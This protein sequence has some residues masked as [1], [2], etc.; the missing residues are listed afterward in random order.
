MIDSPAHVVSLDTIASRADALGLDLRGAFNPVPD[1]EIP[2]LP[3][4]RPVRTLVLLG[5]VGGARW[6]VFAGSPEKADG[7]PDPLDRWSRRVIGGL[8]D[9]LGAT[10][11]FLLGERQINFQRCARRAE[12]V[13]PSPV[14]VL[15]HPEHGLW[16]S[17][18]GALAF[19]DAIDCPPPE[20]TASPCE[21]CIE[22]PCLS[23]CPVGAYTPGRYDLAACAEHLRGPGG[24]I[25]ATLNCRARGACPVGALYRYSDAQTLFHMSN[26]R[27]S[28][29]RHVGAGLLE[30][31]TKWKPDGKVG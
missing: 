4:G 24:D 3:D 14:G 19:A 6:P 22:K 11:F 17:Y 26:F 1:D 25:C 20:Q 2:A 15:I 31:D 9:S 23:A 30:T 13:Y 10:A 16:H 5:W 8:A 27:R 18:R 21:S 29:Q 7:Q 28:I 12:P